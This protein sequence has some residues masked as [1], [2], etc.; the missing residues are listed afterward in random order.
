MIEATEKITRTFEKNKMPQWQFVDALVE[1]VLKFGSKVD[2]DILLG[3]FL[4][5]PT[6]YKRAILLSVVNRFG[7]LSHSDKLLDK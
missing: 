6:D 1:C 4:E 5:N 7:D 2:A 3:C